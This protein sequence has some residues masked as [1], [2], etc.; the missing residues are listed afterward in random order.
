MRHPPP[1]PG[2]NMPSPLLPEFS[3]GEAIWA[4][5]QSP[6]KAG[7][8]LYIVIYGLV[9]HSFTGVWQ[10]AGVD[11]VCPSRCLFDSGTAQLCKSG[12][13]P[14]CPIV[15]CPVPSRPLICHP[16]ADR[17]GCA[18]EYFLGSG[19][20][21]GLLGALTGHPMPGACTEATQT[22][23]VC[24]THSPRPAPLQLRSTSVIALSCK[25]PQ[26]HHLCLTH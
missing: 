11:G 19:G 8:G 3:R 25:Q 16:L 13:Q 20:V 23:T 15:A 4:P 1:P 18:R 7:A 17:A 14:S 6:N 22:Q 10:P 12:W 24:G 21:L 9:R 2:C 26:R 5:P